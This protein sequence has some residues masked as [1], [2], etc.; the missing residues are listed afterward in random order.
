MPKLR[1]V[2]ITWYRVYVNDKRNTWRVLPFNDVT[3]L[4]SA[5]RYCRIWE[6]DNPGHNYQIRLWNQNKICCHGSVNQLTGHFVWSTAAQDNVTRHGWSAW[7]L[8]GIAGNFWE[9][10]PSQAKDTAQSAMRLCR[11]WESKE[12]ATGSLERNYQLR[13]N[14]QVR[15]TGCVS[16]KTGCLQWTRVED[17]DKLDTTKPIVLGEGVPYLHPTSIELSTQ[18]GLVS[19]VDL[20]EHN[21]L[22]KLPPHKRPRCRLL[23]EI[24]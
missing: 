23:L 5:K 10:L 19:F 2:P 24:C 22:F 17:V 15:Y 14:D 12:S 11:A 18:N 4:T 21:E 1:I 16:K 9:K 3:T 20:Y 6:K 8:K 13:H 7:V